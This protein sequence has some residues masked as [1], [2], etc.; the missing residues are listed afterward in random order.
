[1]FWGISSQNCSPRGH[2]QAECCTAKW[3]LWLWCD[4]CAGTRVC[5]DTCVH[6]T[7]DRDKRGHSQKGCLDPAGCARSPPQLLGPGGVLVGPDFGHC[8]LLPSLDIPSFTDWSSEQEKQFTVPF[9]GAKGCWK[10]FT[11]D[12]NVNN[13]NLWCWIRNHSLGVWAVAA[14]WLLLL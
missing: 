13:S 10:S 7:G 11:H 8:I 5:R 1:M 6:G 4:A 12:Q 9:K 2:C 3:R 14:F